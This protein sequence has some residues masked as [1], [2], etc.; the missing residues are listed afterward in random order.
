[1]RNNEFWG[2]ISQNILFT[3]NQAV[4]YPFFKQRNVTH[5]DAVV[6]TGVSTRGSPSD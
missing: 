1:M 5:A 6:L 2:F 3:L 4:I